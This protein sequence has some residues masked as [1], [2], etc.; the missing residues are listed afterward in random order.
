VN[1]IS[2]TGV[3]W[4]RQKTQ[5]N[6]PSLQVSEIWLGFVTGVNASRTAQI[7]LNGSAS[8]N[9]SNFADICEYSPALTRDFSGGGTYGT[10]TTLFTGGT[11]QTLKEHSEVWIGTG[12]TGATWHSQSPSNG[13]LQL[14]GQVDYNGGTISYLEKILTTDSSGY[15]AYCSVDIGAYTEWVGAIAAFKETS[16]DSDCALY[17]T[18]QNGGKGV[19]LWG[20]S[21]NQDFHLNPDEEFAVNFTLSQPKCYTSEH[22]CCVSWDLLI[23][24]DETTDDHVLVSYSLNGDSPNT[25]KHSKIKGHD[26]TEIVDVSQR[27]SFDQGINTLRFT[28]LSTVGVWIN[29]LRVIREYGMCSLSCQQSNPCTGSPCAGSDADCLPEVTRTPDGSFDNTR[30]DYPCNNLNCGGYST[31]KFGPDASKGGIISP[32]SYFE[33][34]FI[35]PPSQTSNYVGSYACFFNLNN[36]DW[37]AYPRSL[38]AGQN[39]VQFS[40]S[41]NGSPSVSMYLSKVQGDNVSAGVDLAHIFAGYYYDTPNA[42]NVIRL[43][44]N[45]S[46]VSLRLNDGSDEYDG[47]RIDVYRY[48]R[49]QPVC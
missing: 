5:D 27:P 37:I 3:I 33:W 19:T 44:N 39:D 31:T 12:C 49:T 25:S 14:D 28:N 29:N 40:L 11:I 21:D 32:G 34:A 8:V 41:V 45:D 42:V 6:S 9:A 46:N 22:A 23:D 1:H 47:G 30:E 15:G 26:I 10:S 18:N 13:F 7:Y 2:Q 4:S 43:T 35:N 20:T 17:G 48:Y 36:I 38:N 24:N 16:S